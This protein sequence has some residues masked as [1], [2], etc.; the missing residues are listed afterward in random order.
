MIDGYMQAIK[1]ICNWILWRYVV[2]VACDTW[3]DAGFYNDHE[4]DF[5]KL[6]CGM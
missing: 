4:E 3:F 2:C 6:I 1:S 5:S